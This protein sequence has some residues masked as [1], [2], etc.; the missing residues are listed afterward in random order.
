MVKVLVGKEQL[1]VA[2]DKI[3]FLPLFKRTFFKTSSHSTAL[4][5]KISLGKGTDLQTSTQTSGAVNNLKVTI[6][7]IHFSLIFLKIIGSLNISGI[8]ACIYISVLWVT[9]ELLVN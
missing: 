5:S 3:G 8:V 2:T 6:T 9:S 4:K 1:M 7:R